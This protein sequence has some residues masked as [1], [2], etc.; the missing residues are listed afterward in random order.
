MFSYKDL[1]PFFFSK[2]DSGIDE[3]SHLHLGEQLLVHLPYLAWPSFAQTPFVV[4]D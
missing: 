4:S 2:V 1:H 3:D